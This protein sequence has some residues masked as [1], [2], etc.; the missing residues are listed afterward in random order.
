MRRVANTAK[1][2]K[3]NTPCHLYTEGTR[4]EKGN[5]NTLCFIILRRHI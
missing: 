4:G 2:D 5:C 3:K 1:E